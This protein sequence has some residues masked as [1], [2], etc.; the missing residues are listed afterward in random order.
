M[1]HGAEWE[2]MKLA[3]AREIQRRNRER[4]EAESRKQPVAP[5]PK[6]AE[7]PVRDE[8]FVPI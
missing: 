2:M 4:A 3:Y 6:P 8:D 7:A 1:C 5:P